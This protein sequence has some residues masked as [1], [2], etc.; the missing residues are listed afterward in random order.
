MSDINTIIQFIISYALVIGLGFGLI[1]F[2]S[3]GFV[4]TFIRAKAS[5][6]KLPLLRIHGVTGEY[7]RTGKLNGE[8]LRYKTKDKKFK[9]L[10]VSQS[11]TKRLMGV[12]GFEIDD[13]NNCIVTH[14]FSAI[15]GFDAEKID[16]LIQRALYRPALMES[17]DKIIIA[18]L[19]LILI[20]VALSVYFGYMNGEKINALTMIKGANIV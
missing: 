18:L 9:T 12:V 3:N 1:N 7:Y 5:R 4:G 8:E 16:S 2:L 17:K 10:L 6:G 13:V 20:G 11:D 14:D 15:E 19:V